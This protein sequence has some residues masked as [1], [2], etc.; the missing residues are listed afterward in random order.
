MNA[1]TKAFAQ[2]SADEVRFLGT[3][4]VP[5][6]PY[7]D[8]QWYEQ[9]RKAIFL[10]EWIE[11]GHICELPE[12][13]SFIRRD[14]EFAQA[15]LLIVRGKDGEIRAFH[16]VC[17]HRGTQLVEEEQGR[18]S[19]FSCPYH[20]WT[21]GT[22]GALISAPDFGQ[23][24]VPKAD[25][26]LPSIALEVCAGLIFINFADDP[27][28]LRAWL[29]DLAEKLET[30]PVAK[31]TTFSEYV[32]DIEANW[33]LTYDNFQ[34]NYHLRFIHPRTGQATLSQD[35]PFGYPLGYGFHGRHRTQSIWTNPEPNIQQVQGMAFGK[36]YQAGVAR[37]IV[38]GPYDREYFALFPNFFLLGTPIQHFSHVVYPVSATRSRGVIR[39]YWV[40]EDRNAS[41]RFA[42]EFAMATARDI[43]AEDRSVIAAGQRGLSSG[44]LKHIHFQTQESLCRHLFNSVRDTVEAWQAEQQATGVQA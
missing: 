44:A 19:T 30:L 43:H 1:P 28:P 35:N 12:P 36:G 20:R 15:S 6:A 14:L 32:Y 13:G 41:E 39:L 10:R 27:Q 34:E 40:G 33:K 8:A 3:D 38:G 21:F 5:A 24:H 18:K 17:T 7:Y 9:E 2:V 22:D 31:A 25:C 4:P 37:G 23:F 42:R 26:A 29:G 11:I 16:N